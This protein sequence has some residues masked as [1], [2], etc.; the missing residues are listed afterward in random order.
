MD[1]ATEMRGILRSKSPSSSSAPPVELPKSIL[2]R[3]KDSPGSPGSSNNSSCEEV[4]RVPVEN[5]LAAKLLDVER[6]AKVGT[7]PA[8]ASLSDSG[9]DPSAL[10]SIPVAQLKSQLLERLRPAQPKTTPVK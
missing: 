7:N 8:S 9:S 3:Q 4:Y 2:K 1:N 6:A 5:N 10:G